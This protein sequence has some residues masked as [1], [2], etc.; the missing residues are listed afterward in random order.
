[1]TRVL[2]AGSRP[3]Q[4]PPHPAEMEMCFVSGQEACNSTI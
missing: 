3:L 2:G 1:M 4:S